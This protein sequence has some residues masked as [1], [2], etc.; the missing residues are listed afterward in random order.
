M[1]HAQPA[2]NQRKHADSDFATTLSRVPLALRRMRAFALCVCAATL[3]GKCRF[4]AGDHTPG[5]EPFQFRLRQPEL[6][7]QYLARMLAQ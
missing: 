6:F 5:F 2:L 7:D 4:R 1:L 3:G